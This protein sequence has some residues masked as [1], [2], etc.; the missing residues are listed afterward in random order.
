MTFQT[1]SDPRRPE[2]LGG[3]LDAVALDAF[4][5][6]LEDWDPYWTVLHDF[7]VGADAQRYEVGIATSAVVRTADLAYGAA[8]LGAAEA[9]VRLRPEEARRIDQRGGSGGDGGDDADTVRR[10]RRGV[11]WGAPRPPACKTYE[12]GERRCIVRM[13]PLNLSDK[14]R[15][16]RADTHL[17]PRGTFVQVGGRVAQLSQRKQ[18]SHDA[19]LWKGMCHVLDVTPYIPHPAQ[20][21]EVQLCTRDDGVYA[22]QIAVCEYV[23]YERLFR[24]MVGGDQNGGRPGTLRVLSYREGVDIAMR[25]LEASHV[26][27]DDSDDDGGDGASPADG[28]G[29]KV[30][31]LTLS[32]LCQVSGRAMETPVRGR[33][34]RHLQCFDLRTWLHNNAIVS[35]G[36]W[37]CALCETW[38]CPRDLLRCGLFDRMLEKHRGEVSGER[39]KVQFRSDGTWDLMAENRLRYG[40]AGKKRNGD[41]GGAGNEANK[42]GK[43]EEGA[44]QEP[45][46][47]IDI[48]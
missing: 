3:A 39:D 29:D 2:V 31:A 28:T 7:T 38:V 5:D 34:C 33:H 18:Q 47:V 19:S 45:Q 23:S 22:L 42:R 30:E 46:E 9:S 40:G 25:H 48:E 10:R 14:D 43:S 41:G 24:R 11:P 26:V 6:R 27:I 1:G 32:L 4:H 12:D 15:K 16:K 21:T 44:G 8:P 20:R 17:W 35:G 13:L 36:R 37:R